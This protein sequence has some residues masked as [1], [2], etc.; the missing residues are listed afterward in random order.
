MRR[1]DPTTLTNRIIKACNVPRGLDLPEITAQVQAASTVVCATAR[2]LVAAGRLHRA[3]SRKLYRYFAQAHQAAQYQQVFAAEREEIQKAKLRRKQDRAN[4]ARRNAL[5]RAKGL[6]PLPPNAQVRIHGSDRYTARILELC[7]RPGG[8]G[9]SE[10]K[11]A[12]QAPLGTISNKLRKLSQAGTLHRRGEPRQ[13]RYFT[14]QAHAEAWEHGQ[15]SKPA[16]APKPKHGPPITIGTSKA[17]AAGQP[18]IADATRVTWP[19]HVQ[20]QRAPVCRDN[21]YTFTPPPGW[22]GEL[23][24]EW[25]QRRRA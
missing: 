25:Q 19:A 12:I 22:K 11:A 20:V 10:I 3:G 8:M 24:Q 4:A 9:C 5:R 14:H 18:N 2:L 15:A 21:R 16:A 13:Y 1:D 23:M 6:P 17:K 7:A